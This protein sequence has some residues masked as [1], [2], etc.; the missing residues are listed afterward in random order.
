MAFKEEF[1]FNQET[2]DDDISEHF[3]NEERMYGAT[4]NDKISEAESEGFNNMY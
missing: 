4:I 2:D 1:I 3:R